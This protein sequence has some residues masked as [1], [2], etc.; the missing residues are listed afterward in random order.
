MTINRFPRRAPFDLFDVLPNPVPSATI[1]MEQTQAA[2]ALV[3]A[4]ELV[5]MEAVP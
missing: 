5:H 4:V 2:G 3:P 1:D